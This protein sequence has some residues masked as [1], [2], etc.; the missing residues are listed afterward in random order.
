MKDDVDPE[1]RRQLTELFDE[2][3]AA[4]IKAIRTELA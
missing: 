1:L 3:L 4:V 2:A